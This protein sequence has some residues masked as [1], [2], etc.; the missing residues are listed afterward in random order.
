MYKVPPG[1]GYCPNHATDVTLP[2]DF[3]ATPLQHVD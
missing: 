2:A 1:T 3:K